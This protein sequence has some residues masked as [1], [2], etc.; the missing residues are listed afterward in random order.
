MSHHSRFSGAT[1]RTEHLDDVQMAAKANEIVAACEVGAP[2]SEPRVVAK[3]DIRG[4]SRRELGIVPVK[5][6]CMRHDRTM[7]HDERRTNGTRS[8]WHESARIGPVGRQWGCKIFLAP[9]CDC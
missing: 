1:A 5:N 6:P 7:I 8:R 3:I 9:R 2:S 4:K